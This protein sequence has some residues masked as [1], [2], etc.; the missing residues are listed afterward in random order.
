MILQYAK[1]KC[2]PL[3]DFLYSPPPSVMMLWFLNSISHKCAQNTI[4]QPPH[5]LH[6]HHHANDENGLQK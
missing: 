5:P 6:H 4:T 2:F 1:E 3:S